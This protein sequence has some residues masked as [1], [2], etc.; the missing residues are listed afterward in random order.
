MGMSQ[1]HGF[2]KYWFLVLPYYIQET[3]KLKMFKEL[4]HELEQLIDHM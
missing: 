1:S 4:S 3:Q 2:L